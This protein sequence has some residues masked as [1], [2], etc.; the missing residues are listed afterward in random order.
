VSAGGR[1]LDKIDALYEALDSASPGDSLDLRVVR[2]TDE[3][4]IT[5][6]LEADEVTA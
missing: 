3:R 1:P 4:D 6:R 5:V 2:G